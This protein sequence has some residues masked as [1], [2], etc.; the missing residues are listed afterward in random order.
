M[1]V[2]TSLAWVSRG[3]ARTEPI[4]QEVQMDDFEDFQEN[5]DMQ[6]ENYDQENPDPVF[7]NVEYDA[8]LEDLKDQEEEENCKIQPKDALI[9][10][11]VQNGDFSELDV[12][13]YVEETSA[14]YVHHDIILSAYPLDL[15]WLPYN[16]QNPGEVGNCLAVGSFLP[17]IE[18]WNLDL[19]DA[20]EPVVSLGGVKR[21]EN[22]S[23]KKK[24]KTKTYKKGS[25][26]DAVMSLDMHPIRNNIL[27]SG[28]AD[29]QV[30]LWD[31]LENKCSLTLDHHQ[32]KVQAVKWNPTEE[33]II[34]TG[35]LDG[36]L[37]VMSADSPSSR[38]SASVP[39]EVESISWDP[40]SPLKVSITTEDG[41]LNTYDARNLSAPLL[42]V[43]A[44]KNQS[45]ARYSPG[46]PN[47]LATASTDCTV[48]LWD[49]QNL[50]RIQ[51]KDMKVD[52]LLCLEFYK[53]SPYILATGGLGGE[54]AVWDTE[55][56]S[57]V[58][59]HFSK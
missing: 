3:Y 12:Y 17:E 54:I 52:K 22:K 30:K 21:V 4:Q 6:L 48:S 20:L 18:V 46:V 57:L 25:H 24:K 59:S 35:G 45:T 53:D 34:A 39:S 40:F 19:L 36:N 51:E 7:T 29:T 11:G 58:T 15:Q 28:S 31:V 44:H 26:R 43:K 27:A 16:P 2:I 13:V 14:L 8:Q 33:K 5:N 42:S 50:T 56:S 1:S 49:A 32:G 41:F 38:I 10:A 37:F 9:V 23:G 55:E 47:L